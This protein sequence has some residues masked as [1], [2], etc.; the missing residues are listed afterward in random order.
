MASGGEAGHV[1]A[2]LGD[3]FLGAGLADAGDLIELGH[4]RR[5]RG[6]RL[7]DPP[8]QFLDLGGERVDPVE[9]HFSR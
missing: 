8:G 2:D 5:E 6:D 4:L 3:E 9:H 1:G 7:I